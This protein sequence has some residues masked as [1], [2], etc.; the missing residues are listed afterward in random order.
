[1][2]NQAN[3]HASHSSES[4][5]F[6]YSYVKATAC[7][8]SYDDLK[9]APRITYIEPAP[10]NEF[11][12]KLTTAVYDQ[13][14][15]Q[16][17]S[18][19]YTVIRE[20]SENFIHAQFKEIVVSI[21]DKGNT[22]RFADQGPGIN[23]KDNAQKPGFTSAIEPMKRYIR[24]VGSGLPIVREYLDTSGGYISIEDNLSTGA[25]VTVSLE[26]RPAEIPSN[27][28]IYPPAH[29]HS[30]STDKQPP[31]SPI[32][33]PVPKLTNREKQFLSVLLNENTMG[34]TELAEVTNTPTT[35]AYN[36]LSKLEQHGLVEHIPGGKKRAL[37]S[38]GEEVARS[39]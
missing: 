38:F 18:I 20:V 16:G 33:I 6:D 32:F 10:T 11:I 8:A 2:D 31:D 22:I 23:E 14:H 24:G 4:P 17:G 13:S 15:L 34:V 19:P 12:E 21:L 29:Q 30:S 9:T 27:T 5:L 36:T 1:M 37:T 3:N 7:V 25:V 26:S 35:S 28:T 39:L